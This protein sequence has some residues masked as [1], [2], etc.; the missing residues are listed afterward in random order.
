MRRIGK[1]LGWIVAVVLG[2]PLLLVAA[3]LIAGNTDPGRHLIE[4]LT[5]SL[6]GREIRLA[7]LAGRFPDRLR[8]RRLGLADKNGAHLTTDGL[9][10]V[11]SPTRLL[12]GVLDVDRLDAGTADFARVPVSSSGSS[13]GLPVR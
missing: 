2:V 3:L 9:A 10:F 11:W 1:I 6:T 8:A 7:G 5:P 12:H 13:S 4:R